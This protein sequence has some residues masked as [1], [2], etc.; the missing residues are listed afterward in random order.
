[1]TEGPSAKIRQINFMGNHVFS[2]GTL[3]DEMQLSTP[4][5]FSWYTKNDLYA[6]DK[7][8]GDLE[9]VRSILSE[10]RLSG[11][12]HRLP[13]QVSISPDKKDMYL[14]VS[15]HEGEPYMV[16]NIKLG[17]NLLDREAELKKLVAMMEPRRALFGCEIAGHHTGG[18]R[19]AGRIRL[20]VRSG[21]CAAGHRSGTSH[22]C[23]HASG[24]SRPSRLCTPRVNI[25]G[26]TRTRDEVIRREMRQIES[27]WFDSS[28][29]KLSKERVDR[30]G[31]F[32]N[33]EVTT[34]PVANVDDE[35]DVNVKVEEK[36][37][38]A[39]T[40]FWARA[41]IQVTRSCSRR[42]SHKTMYSARARPW[43]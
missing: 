19:Q 28:R 12:Q 42:A 13:T 10:S 26:N 1:M 38:G 5:W 3:L 24:G 22:R 30:L 14:T 36:P 16:S 31:Y 23:N 6:K 43:R 39:I 40:L 35:V 20:R 4:N 15:I 41:T 25:E 34:A 32:T 33:V 18:R 29:L 8:S 11:V 17:G 9:H 37:T 27:S 2:S 7:L 21:Q